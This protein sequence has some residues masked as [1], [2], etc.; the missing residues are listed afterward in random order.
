MLAARTHEVLQADAVALRCYF[1][2]A[3]VSA[4]SSSNVAAS[5]AVCVS[6]ILVYVIYCSDAELV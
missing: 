6:G 2:L 3:S 5:Q 4:H 1:I